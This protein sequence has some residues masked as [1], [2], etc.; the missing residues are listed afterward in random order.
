[1]TEH[2]EGLVAAPFTAMNPDCSINLE[3][4]EKQANF[5][6]DNGVQGAFICG[7]TGESMSLNTEER[8]GIAQRWVET[9]PEGLKIIVHVGHTSIE[10]CKTLAA[11]AQK[12]GAWGIGAMAPSFFVPAKVE[13]LV[14]FCAEVAA[15]AP[16]LP[17]YYYHMPSITHVNFPM[18]SFLEHASE[19][20]P[21]L[22]GIKYTYEDLMDY[23]LCLNYDC[24]RYDILF[25][26]D[27]ILV[28]ALSLG[29]RGAVGSTYNFAAPLYNKLIKAF[30]SGDIELARELQKQSVDI[31]QVIVKSPGSFHSAGKAIMTMLGIDFGPVRSPLCNIT[32]L[33]YQ[34]LKSELEKIGFFENGSVNKA[35]DIKQR[36]TKYAIS[37]VKTNEKAK[38][39]PESISQK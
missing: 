15:S 14:S 7:T 21:T 31:I 36:T 37:E 2:I 11:H 3:A 18:I 25:G 26:R 34:N 32:Q 35:P 1:M 24:G 9:S 22:A 39:S 16:D 30:D 12:I 19:K 27:E 8:K 6:F 20:I 33:Q 10:D 38:Q 13:D 23:Q 17:F 4:I 28:C 5:L 29:A